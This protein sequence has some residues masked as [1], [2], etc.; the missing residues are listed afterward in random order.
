V[1]FV[2]SKPLTAPAGMTANLLFRC[3]ENVGADLVAWYYDFAPRVVAH[4]S[5][6]ADLTV[7]QEGCAIFRALVAEGPSPAAPIRALHTFHST[8]LLARLG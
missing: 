4:F 5:G 3:R 1:L 7:L 8:V 6:E 2:P